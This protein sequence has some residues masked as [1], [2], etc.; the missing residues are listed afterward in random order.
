[1]DIEN[2]LEDELDKENLDPG[3]IKFINRYSGVI[4]VGLLLILIIIGVYTALKYDAEANNILSNPCKACEEYHN[5]EC[6]NLTLPKN[7]LEL[8]FGASINGS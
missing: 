2:N 3:L 8:E 4:V 7:P 6:I 5:M 1:M